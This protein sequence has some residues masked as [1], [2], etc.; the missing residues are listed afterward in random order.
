MSHKCDCK[1]TC[2]FPKIFHNQQDCKTRVGL[3]GTVR[4]GFALNMESHCQAGDCGLGPAG[5][6]TTV[7]SAS[8]SWGVLSDLMASQTSLAECTNVMPWGLM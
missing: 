3:K 7:A 6:R 5:G 2:N 1:F 4:F 8:N